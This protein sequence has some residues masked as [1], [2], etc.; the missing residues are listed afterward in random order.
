MCSSDLRPQHEVAAERVP[1]D[2]KFEALTVAL[3]ALFVKTTDAQRDIIGEL[4]E[5][6]DVTAQTFGA[7]VT[8][9]VDAMHRR[10]GVVQIVREMEV[11]P[12]VLPHPVDDEHRPPRA[13]GR[14]ACA[15]VAVRDGEKL[16][17]AVRG[18][19]RLPVGLPALRKIG[20]AFRDRKS[21]RLNSSHT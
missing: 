8:P 10:N 18:G 4:L 11:A 2:M 7:T 9:K 17:S 1:E 13:L 16:Q 20:K 14:N 19:K 5:A 12:T 15:P 21:T 6:L 3:Y